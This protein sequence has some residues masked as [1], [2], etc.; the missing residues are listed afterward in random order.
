MI[1]IYDAIT[2]NRVVRTN[3][4]DV[5]IQSMHE[6]TPMDIQEVHN[7][8]HSQPPGATYDMRSLGPCVPPFPKVFMEYRTGGEKAEDELPPVPGF[9]PVREGISIVTRRFDGGG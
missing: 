3:L 5:P 8:W 1:R 9:Y 2:R 6:A 4:G 7:W